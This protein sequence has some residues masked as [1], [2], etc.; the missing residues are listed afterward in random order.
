VFSFLQQIQRLF[1]VFQPSHHIHLQRLVY[2]RE[3]F[4]STTQG[5]YKEQASTH[6]DLLFLQ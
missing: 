1:Y 3:A 5:A 4:A 6:L 2:V